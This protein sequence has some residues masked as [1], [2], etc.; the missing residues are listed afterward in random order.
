MTIQTLG[1]KSVLNLN[2]PY[3]IFIYLIKSEEKKSDTLFQC[4]NIQCLKFNVFLFSKS[5]E[6]DLLRQISSPTID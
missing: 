6:T 1:F 3:K 5:D 2:L 4:I